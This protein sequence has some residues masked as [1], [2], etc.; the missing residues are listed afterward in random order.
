MKV[1][2]NRIALH[3]K[4]TQYKKYSVTLL[5][6]S[7]TQNSPLFMIVMC[8][9]RFLKSFSKKKKVSFCVCFYHLIL[10]FYFSILFQTKIEKKKTKI[11]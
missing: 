10:I 11:N 9:S 8:G 6:V 4:C 1:E 3:N 2:T 5:L 7:V